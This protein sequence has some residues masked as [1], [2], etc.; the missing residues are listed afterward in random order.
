MEIVYIP[1]MFYWLW[2]SI[3]ARSPFFFS[4]SNPGIEFGG[5]LGESKIKI[6]KKID[7]ELKPKTLY[8]NQ[9]VSIEEVL[10]KIEDASLSFPL[11]FK[12]DIGERGLMVEKIDTEAAA[13][14]YVDS[15]K[16]NFLVQEYIDLPIELGVFY[17]RYPNRSA[18][19][20]SSIVIKE[21]LKITGD[22]KST[23]R[24]LI[25]KNP[26]A[27]LQLDVLEHKYGAEMESILPMAKEKLLVPIGNHCKGAAFLD[28][29]K[30]I[31]K[32]MT[33]SFDKIA[34]EIDGF[35][36]GR[37]DLKCESWEDL[38]DG[39]MKIMELNGSG[40]EPGHI[41]HPGASIWNAYE[42]L[43]FH[44]RVLL[45]ISMINK[46]SGV[47]YLTWKE[48]WYVFTQLPTFKKLGFT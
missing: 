4:A 29:G 19:R 8:F 39:N 32:K 42:S 38:E 6:L 9:N 26:R 17:F 45:R 2:L 21:F 34:K 44:M 3:K 48:G 12:P 35:F 46:K 13:T 18:G 7:D 16:M 27:K 25:R 11:I 23:I 43:F 10:N 31:T 24:N 47:K 20:I 28:G 36:I 30:R 41:Y 5:M 1:V 15:I 40:A 37:F 22:G 33:R 14:N